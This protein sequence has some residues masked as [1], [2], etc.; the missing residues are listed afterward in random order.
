MGSHYFFGGGMCLFPIIMI[1]M[2]VV[3]LTGSRLMLGQGGFRPSGQGSRTRGGRH[4]VFEQRD[5]SPQPSHFVNT[6][7]GSDTEK[8]LYAPPT[9]PSEVHFRPAQPS[10]AKGHLASPTL[11][12]HLEKARAYQAQ[13][14]SLMKSTSNQKARARLQDLTTQVSEWTKTIEDMAKRVDSFQ[15]NP[16]IHQ[17]LESVPQAIEKLEAQLANESDDIT[18]LELE[19]TLVNRKN[20]LAALER[21]QSTI[22]RAEI[23]MESTLSALGTIYSQ[24]LTAQSTNQVAGY[25]RLLAEV[26]EEVRTLQDYLEALEEVKLG[27]G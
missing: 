8:P 17:D 26:N 24:V 27:W 4:L 14:N 19:R 12:A 25:S 16:L 6:L 10:R 15:Q 2:C 22:K 1:I 13:I 18:G 7:L 11:Q 23:K 3:M 5:F 20:Q 9:A 21:L